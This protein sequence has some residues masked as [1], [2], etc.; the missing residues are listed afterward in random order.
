MKNSSAFTFV[1]NFSIQF[2]FIV[3]CFSFM[4]FVSKQLYRKI[5]VFTLQF[6]DLLSYCRWLCQSNVHMSKMYSSKIL[7]I[8]Q[9]ISCIHLGR[10]KV[11]ITI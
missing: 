6:S 2:K 4:H 9:L 10:D 5:N 3:Q 11:V 1:L 8:M 7:Q